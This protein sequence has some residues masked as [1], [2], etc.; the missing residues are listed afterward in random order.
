MEVGHVT[1]AQLTLPSPHRDGGHHNP[2]NQHHPRGKCGFK[3]QHKIYLH[4]VLGS[5]S[6]HLWAFSKKFKHIWLMQFS[7]HWQHFL[8]FLTT[9]HLTFS[10]VQHNIDQKRTFFTPYLPHLVN[11][12]SLWKTSTGILLLILIFVWFGY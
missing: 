3:R 9:C 1:Y 4:R 7:L 5:C 10:T 2:F 8:L 11:V 6:F 12:E